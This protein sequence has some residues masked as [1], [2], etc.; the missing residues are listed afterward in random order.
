LASA[1]L[2]SLDDLSESENEKLWGKEALSRHDEM[3]KG[4]VKAKPANL[5]FKDARAR[6]K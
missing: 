3:I 4:K 6:L 5:V 1:L 2:S